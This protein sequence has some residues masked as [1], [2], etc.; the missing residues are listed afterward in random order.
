M[1][2]IRRLRHA[3]TW[4][5]KEET[6]AFCKRENILPDKEKN[7]LKGGHFYNFCLKKRKGLDKP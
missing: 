4:K 3:K 5:R 6:K 7:I 1:I 2:T